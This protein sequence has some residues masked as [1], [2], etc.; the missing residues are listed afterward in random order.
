MLAAGA[1]V[2]LP[3]GVIEVAVDVAA[4]A[5]KENG[6]AAAVDVVAV[7]VAAGAPNVNGDVV[8]VVGAV[9]APNVNGDDD[10]AVVVA[11]LFPNIFGVL[12]VGFVS[13]V[14]PLNNDELVA[15]DGNKLVVV[16]EANFRLST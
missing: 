13:V 6:A 14:E 9:D 16:A 10:V 1:V 11:V 8:A 2:V 12:V 5:P 15:A 7:A 4:G 3:N